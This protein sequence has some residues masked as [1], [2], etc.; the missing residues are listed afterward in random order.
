MQTAPEQKAKRRGVKR[1]IRGPTDLGQTARQKALLPLFAALVIISEDDSMR[2]IPDPIHESQGQMI[3]KV[4]S[5]VVFDQ[6]KATADAN[7]FAE[8]DG[9]ILRVMQDIHEKAYVKGCFIEWELLA[10]KRLARDSAPRPQLEFHTLDE[11][12]R[13]QSRDET[14]DGPVTAADI[15]DGSALRDLSS[16]KFCKDARPALK[17]KRVMPASDPR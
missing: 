12:V 9:R 16:K 5:Q 1:H 10:V 17:N 6:H 2:A 11:N 15:Q 8:Q 7:R 14:A 13:T 4:F 3:K